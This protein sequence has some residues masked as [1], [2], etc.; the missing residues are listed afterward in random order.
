[1]A[2]AATTLPVALSARIY[3]GNLPWQTGDHQLAEAFSHLGEVIEA[4]VRTLSA[5]VLPQRVARAAA[6]TVRA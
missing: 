2:A 1:M 5:F 3:V 6:A 4:K